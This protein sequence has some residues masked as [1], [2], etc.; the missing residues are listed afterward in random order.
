MVKGKRTFTK[1]FKAQFDAA[2]AGQRQV[3]QR[4]IDRP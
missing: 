1:E 3:H 2:G 4:A